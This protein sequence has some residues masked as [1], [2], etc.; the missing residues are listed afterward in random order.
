MTLVEC[1]PFSVVVGKST[2]KSN[3]LQKKQVSTY[4]PQKNTNLYK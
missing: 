1:A 2:R 4:M 3:T